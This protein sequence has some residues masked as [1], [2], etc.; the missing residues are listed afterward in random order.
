MGTEEATIILGNEYDDALR[1]AI[2]TVLVRNGAV[3]IDKL[4][5]VGGSQEIENLVVRL[6]ID[7]I[8]IEAETFVGLTIA[9]PKA[10]VEDIARQ[11]G[12]I[13]SSDCTRER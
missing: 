11:V 2:H 6:G 8:T 13:H 3:G 1:D 4:W 12:Q 5:G 9:G 7:L 10:I